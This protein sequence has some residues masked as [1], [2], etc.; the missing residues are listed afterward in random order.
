MKKTIFFFILIFLTLLSVSAL[1]E[2][3]IFSYTFESRNDEKAWSGTFFDMS[4]NFGEGHCAYIIN[5]F[6]E[7]KKERITHVIDYTDKIYLEEGKTYTLSGYVMNPL[8]DYN[9]S[10]RT[11]ANL[12]ASANT[13]I[14]T[15]SGAD[16]EWSKFT[17]TFYAGQTGYFNLSI[18]F[19]EGHVDFGFFVDELMLSETSHTIKA[20]TASGPSQVL[21]PAKN[22]TAVSFNTALTASDGTTISILSA[23]SVA[24]TCSQA[25]GIS[26]NS[27][28]F[29]LTVTKDAPI[30]TRI[31]VDFALK[32]YATLAPCSLTVTLTDN[33][34]NDFSSSWDNHWT[35]T[36]NIDYVSNNNQNYISLST[37]N[38]GNFG[39]FSTIN[40]NTPQ[41]LIEGELYVMRAKVKSDVKKPSEAIYAKN[42]VYVD[43]NTVYFNINDIS[44]DG[45]SDVFCAFVPEV[46]G[47]YSI[48]VNLC[49]TYD[50][51]VYVTDLRLCTEVSAPEY[52]TLHAPG[53][54]SLPDVETSYPVSGLLR[55]QLGNIIESAGVAIYL[56]EDADSIIFDAS[57]E[58]LTIR[59]DTLAGEYTL[60]A[61]SV[62]NPSITASLPF[63]VSHNYVGDGSFEE[64]V[65]NEWWMVT[66]PY[67]SNFYIRSDGDE[68]H[69]LIDC[70]GDYFIL[71]NNSYVHLI[72]GLAYVFNASFS[73]ST[74]VTVTLFLEA[75]DSVLHP[76][77]Q[78]HVPAGASL[79]EKIN[80][81]LFLAEG[82]AVGRIFL[83]IQS[84]NGEPIS[85]YADDLSLKKASIL[86]GNL[87]IR[88]N[89]SVNG[90]AEAHFSFYNSVAQNNDISSCIINWYVSDNPSHGFTM[91]EHSEKNIYFDTTFLNKYVYFEVIPVCPITGF[92][93]ST[94]KSATFKV[95]Y[96]GIQADDVHSFK[97]P[98]LVASDKSIFADTAGH[99]SEEYVN[100]LAE[101]EILNGKSKNVFAPDE[102]ITRAEFAK[103]VACA[104]SLKNTAYFPLF[105]D[106][107]T[108]D[109]FYNYVQVLNL[110]GIINGTSNDTFSPH[111]N[112]TREDAVVMLMR[113]YE[114]FYPAPL[115]FLPAEF[116]DAAAVS[117]YAESYV[118]A[119]SGL[120]IIKG[121]PEGQFNPSSPITRAEAT[122]LLYRIL[123]LLNN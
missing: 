22:P 10:I 63:V 23:D 41:L 69:A 91:L 20:I 40:Y 38:Y 55:D 36:S 62:D 27:N 75:L 5:P 17:T 44:G 107:S 54:I 103:I 85:V 98:T 46:S 68:K 120:G 21:V 89:A 25:S 16:S 1:A 108:T 30:A 115:K 111:N 56:S 66:S 67:P 117:D 33:M 37:N 24:S 106:I 97:L 104:F 116:T 90:Y 76:L 72:E 57:N 82:S 105:E 34:I 15:V 110:Y 80:P 39:Y 81:E 74:D 45:W 43:D 52:I 112:I 61:Y 9:Q 8:N 122:A 118:N 73:S 79:K 28:D 4:M 64:K 109:W 6:G 113:V 29:T 86:A 101:N 92:S 50:T 58:L 49:S 26:Y 102:F 95:T 88:G 13:V 78:F 35:S 14:V 119:A 71:L 53:N 96:E 59:P 51:T 31:T 19:T 7:V 18:H 77:A 60:Y 121:N 12:A 48:A 11:N 83:Y 65:P 32:N 87:H 2:E 94:V 84:D 123:T 93:G 47:I 42:M 99:W 70:S 100:I 114:K 3:N